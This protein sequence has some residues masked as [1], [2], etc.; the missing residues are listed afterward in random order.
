LTESL[1]GR[2]EHEKRFFIDVFSKIR[3]RATFARCWIDAMP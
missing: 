1:A 2:P 3:S